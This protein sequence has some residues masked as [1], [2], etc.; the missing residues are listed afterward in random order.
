MFHVEVKKNK[1]Q[2]TCYVLVEDKKCTETTNEYYLLL[3]EDKSWWQT[4]K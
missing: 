1:P 4:L 3:S 2:P